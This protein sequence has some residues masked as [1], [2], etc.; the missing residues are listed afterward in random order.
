M[1]KSKIK[2][3][4]LFDDLDMSEFSTI[5]DICRSLGCEYGKPAW[6]DKFGEAL[7]NYIEK[8]NIPKIRTLSL[9]SGAGGL[10]IGFHDLGFEIIE[11]VEIEPK[12]CNTLIQNSGE[13]KKFPSSK[14]NCIDIREYTGDNL[15]KIDF[16]I[17]GPPCQTFSAAGRRQGGV[18]GTTDAR[19][20][21][22]R[23]Y[24]RLLK[25]LQPKGF[26]F[27]NV[28]GIIGAQN[29]EA[30]KEIKESFSEVGYKLH[31][32]I[33][34][35]ADYGVPQHR[36][37]LI[38]VGLK[39]GSFKFPRPI[40]GC[41]SI[42]DEPFYSA[43]CAISGLSLTEEEKAIGING[44]FGT[45]INDIPP[46]LNYSFY[47][48]EMGHPNPIFAW[49]SKFSDFMYKADPDE[50]V[51]TIKAQGGQYTGPLHW[52]CRYFAYS[53][54]KRLQTFPDDYTISGVKQ[55]AV[56]QI[57]NSVPPQLARMMALAIRI[58]VFGTKFPFN[59]EFISDDVEL[60]FRKN[61]R[62]LTKH[63]QAK[64]KEAIARLYTGGQDYILKNSDF[65]LTLTDR[66]KY[67][68][69]AEEGD[70]MV[71]I[72]WLRESLNIEVSPTNK[73]DLA[74]ASTII[75]KSNSTW[76]MPVD[77]ISLKVNSNNWLAV[78]AAWKVLDRTLIESKIKADLVQ[79]NGYYQYPS[80]IN[81]LLETNT[82]GR[83]NIMQPIINGD[84]VSKE[85]STAE[86]AEATSVKESEVMDCAKWLRSLGYEIRNNHTNPQI[87]EG[88]WLLPYKFPS[89]LPESVQ[90]NKSLE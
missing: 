35:A 31:Y 22:F 80:Q 73:K 12:F 48:K 19:G 70:Y 11:S 68:T 47:T 25:K 17:G 40:N 65:Y 10:D 66:F 14:P 3:P 53:E 37:R 2:S 8:N 84:I 87:P 89:L 33:L 52:D 45:L 5:R 59:L 79:L 82:L 62:Q 55:V 30:W 83:V 64:A 4:T 63:Y 72:K 1:V 32:R 71:S 46:G 15:G 27:E 51:R 44:R 69:S 61:K 29:G 50:P 56:H 36:E 18:L 23:E 75:I 60:S 41:D 54:F 39:E 78:T 38:I 43:G 16:I 24:V 90:L 21:L 88:I 57:G 49:R 28:Y 76:T 6:C 34:D 7:H 26:L 58:Q 20:M 77:F 81:C 74:E 42:N 85:L 13:G 67:I 9:F 86:F